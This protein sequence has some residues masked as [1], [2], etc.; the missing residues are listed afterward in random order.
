MQ[1][2]RDTDRDCRKGV[3][4]ARVL[5][6]VIAG[7][8]DRPAL[9]QRAMEFIAD[10]SQTDDD[11]ELRRELQRSRIAAAE[12]KLERHRTAIE[13]G[14]DPMAPVAA[15]NAAQAEK[16]SATA[17]LEH[18]PH[19]PRLTVA[20]VEK[21]VDSL[22]DIR[23]VLKAGAA[24]DRAA[25]YAAMNVEILYDHRRRSATMTANPCVL[26]SAGV[27]RGT[28]PLRPR[29]LPAEIAGHGLVDE[30]LHS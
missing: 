26:F 13:A 17:E 2:N 9:G 14:V 18:I 1:E 29:L 4:L 25:L 27:R 5:E 24:E 12:T 28:R 8:T 11:S 16:A 22:G 20:Q 7:Y 6:T 23:A 10:E 15:M 30:Q 3:N 19:T 21:I